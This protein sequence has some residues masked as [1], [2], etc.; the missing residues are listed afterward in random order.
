[1]AELLSATGTFATEGER[2][3]AEVLKQLP[4]SWLLICNKTL[5]TRGGL[6]HEMDFVVVGKR[7]IFL[8][9]EKSWKGKIRGN[10]EQWIRDD[11]SSERSPL[12]KVDYVAKVLAGHLVWRIPSLKGGG[13]FVR[14]GVLLSSAD[15][16][17]QI[18]DSR[19]AKGIFLLNDVCQH[20]LAIDSQDGNPLVGQMRDAIKKA[21]VDLSDR[22]VIPHHINDFFTIN[23]AVTIRPGVRLFHATTDNGEQRLLMVYDLGR[24]PLT[25]KDLR[26][27]YMRE[28]KVMQTLS[29]TGLVAEVKDPFLW[30]DDFIILPIVPLKGTPLSIYPRPE[31]LDELAQELLIAAACFK[32]LD[33]IHSK[34]VLHRAISP[35]IVYVLQSGQS[36]KIAFTNFFAARIGASSIAA[37]LDKLALAAEDPYASFDLAVGYELATPATDTFSLALVFLERIS[38]FPIAAIRANIESDITFPD[39]QR[40]WSFLPNDI[41]AELAALFKEI[42]ISDKHIPSPAEKEIAV[43]LSE[44]ARRLRTE[45]PVEEGKLLLDKRYRVERVLG[46]GTMARTYLASYTDYAD[47]GWCVLKQFLRP[48]DVYEQAVAEYRALQRAKSTY[49]PSIAE[50]YRPQDDVHIKM[51]Y[52]PGPTLQ[53]IETEFPWPLERWWAFAQDLMNAIEELERRQ[54]LHRDIKPS[55]IILHE[56]ENLP[57]LIDFGFAIQRGITGTA[58]L[59]GTP[60]YLP[61]EALSSPVP[62]PTSDR[63]AAAMVLFR[64]L[65]G[66]LPFELEDSQQRTLR[67][68]EQITDEKVR[69][70]AA[71]LLRVVSNDPSERPASVVQ[72]R[73]ALQNAVLAIEEPIEAHQLPELVNPWVENVRSLYRNSTSGNANNRG[74]D[75]QFVRETYVQTALDKHLQP[76]IFA[77][78]PKVVFLTGNPGDGKT[79]FLEQVQKSLAEKGAACHARDTSGWEWVYEG[80]VFRSC[81][82]ASESHD[83]QSA[84]EQLALRLQGL[85]GKAVSEIPLTVLV[86]INDGRLADFFDRNHDRFPWLARQVEQSRRTTA[87]E[88]ATVWVVD[89]KRRSFV[90]FPESDEDSIFRYVVKSLIADEK[91]ALCEGCAAKAI[92]PIRNNARVLSKAR[93]QQRLEYLLLLTHLRRQHHITMRDLR[94]TLAYLITG[95]TDCKDIHEARHAGEA[96]ASLVN[97]AYWRSAFAPLE[98]EDELLKAITSFDPARFPHPHLDR[99]LHFHQDSGAVE[100][101]HMLFADGTD[102]PRQRFT[103][104]IEWIEAIKRRLYFEARPVKAQENNQ[105]GIPRVRAL[106]LLPYRY[107]N[108]FIALLDD[109]L[110]DDEVN[111]VR[112]YL[113][114]GILCSGGIIEDVPPGKLSVQ[115]SASEEQK[116]II[117][118]QFPIEDFQLYPEQVSDERLIESIP[119]IVILEHISG[120]PQLE[121]TIDL[122]ELLMRLANGLLPDSPEYQPLLEDLKP[123]KDALLL[124]ETRDLVLIENHYRVHHI[125]QDAGKIV[126]IAL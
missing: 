94:S 117:L 42:V 1:M 65:T 122:F 20:L 118:K 114:R 67:I 17:P 103:G 66:Y 57:V 89:L 79:A 101:R 80:H 121:I 63:Y 81:Y 15:E 40:R 48:E 7:W 106:S 29:A 53:E 23:D 105:Q 78:R 86:A 47:V 49:L 68:P 27:F 43:R 46:Q 34:G 111:E 64:V 3:A 85:E 26:E 10:D 52:I 99:Y 44:L 12:A 50:I 28:F 32:G 9:D 120:F 74:L 69:R 2:R 72:M 71:V 119:E 107:A 35:D 102:L 22:S 6:S 39:I 37:P 75:T 88:D 59:A 19:A 38:G 70:I 30:S 84:D 51:E 31:T 113:A 83:G 13:H 36:P 109:R 55:N 16:R 82:D 62:P 95:N 125:T 41:T 58:R 56:S 93:I 96:G 116:L 123:F 90:H 18:H 87:L 97:L 100:S 33:V 4:D 76:V 73:Q 104:E 54:L 5:P 91:W 11:G 24:D 25:A 108:L 61:P 21:L 77:D 8:L 115:V 126:R 14:G 124:R 112:K 45:K 92:C 110:D 60:L 98:M